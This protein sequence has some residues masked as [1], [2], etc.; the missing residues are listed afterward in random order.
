VLE[1]TGAA[2]PDRGR[3]A[4]GGFPYPLPGD[5]RTDPHG[6]DQ[7]DARQQ[8]R[9]AADQRGSLRQR[10]PDQFQPFPVRLDR[11]AVGVPVSGKRAGVDKV[12][13][14]VVESE[15]GELAQHLGQVL[16]R[17]RPGDVEHREVLIPVVAGV[18]AAHQPVWMIGGQRAPG[19]DEEGCQPQARA[20]PGVTHSR[21]H[22]GERAGP[23]AA[24]PPVADARLPPVVDLDDLDRK[25]CVHD[26]VEVLQHLPGGDRLPVAVPGAPDR[27]RGSH[28][29][30][31]HPDCERLRPLRQ[32]GP[33]VRVV[34][35]RGDLRI[36]RDDQ[37]VSLCPDPDRRHRP[38][39][40]GCGP[41]VHRGIR[42]RL[43][44][45][46]PFAL[47]PHNRGWAVRPVHHR[48]RRAVHRPSRRPG[49]R[50]DA[51][52]AP[53]LPTVLVHPRTGRLADQL[54]HIGE[55][56]VVV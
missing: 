3:P 16:G 40:S 35:R 44:R 15:V 41:D 18:G 43:H 1:G 29:T 34:D 32:R 36:G 12:Q 4:V 24:G 42:G 52:G 38:L 8:G 20:K 53:G 9:T 27:R 5:V 54:G 10:G 23:V 48:L 17:G 22:R 6:I 33:Q 21:G 49:G 51:G 25:A 26:R 39:G 56:A 46:Q 13:F 55:R 45:D 31:A 2:G 7:P 14:E 50:I 11:A 30:D 37:P 19:A 47:E 28:R